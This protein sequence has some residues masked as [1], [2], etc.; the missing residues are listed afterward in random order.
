MATLE[1]EQLG[2]GQAIAPTRESHVFAAATGRRAGVLRALGIAAGV[3]A[4]A[5]LAALAL[6]LLGAGSLPGLLP[7]AVH[8]GLPQRHQS[9][10]AGRTAPARVR[11]RLLARPAARAVHPATAAASK[12]SSHS[13]SVVTAPVTPAPAAS[14]SRR[15]GWV[16]RGWSA[17]PGQMRR[18]QPPAPQGKKQTDGTKTPPGQSDSHVPPKK[19]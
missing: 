16:R 8:R 7:E 3:L 19:S 14:A 11:Q 13:S 10:S 9:P 15:Q 17:P 6:S 18:S 12:A 2:A 5:W 4:L 1:H